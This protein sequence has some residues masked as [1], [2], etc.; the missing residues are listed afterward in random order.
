M[1]K[2]AETACDKNKRRLTLQH[3]IT[4]EC[5][6][7]EL[8]DVKREI[9]QLYGAE[10]KAREDNDMVQA[11][12]GGT[13]ADDNDEQSPEVLQRYNQWSFQLYPHSRRYRN[14]DNLP[15]ILNCRNIHYCKKTGWVIFLAAGGPSPRAGGEIEVIL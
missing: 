12:E 5:W 4:K 11:D 9:E 10:K 7:A 8:E 6:A 14:I 3:L 15:R 13:G 2:P 1:D